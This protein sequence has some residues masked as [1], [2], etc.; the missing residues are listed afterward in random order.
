MKLYSAHF[1]TFVLSDDFS[2]ELGNTEMSACFSPGCFF[3]YV[4][5][6]CIKLEGNPVYFCDTQKGSGLFCLVVMG[7]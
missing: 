4:N 7:S 5:Q 6:T 1:K 2:K 3:N